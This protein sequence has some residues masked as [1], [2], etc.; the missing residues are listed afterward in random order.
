ML[1]ISHN[2]GLIRETCDR[3]CVMY[4]GQAVE[5]GTI[6]QI[7]AAPRHPYTQGL[8]GCIPTPGRDK[9]SRP[10]VPI[11]GQLPLP[12]N[13]PKGCWF[14]PRCD[15]FE[16]GRCDAGPV[17][18]L[19]ASETR[20]VRCLRWEEI[21]ASLSSRAPVPAPLEVMP[22]AVAAV[23]NDL[24]VLEVS[25]M[26]KHYPIYDSS[27]AAL[28]G[29]DRTRYVRANEAIS[30]EAKGGQ[31]VAIV[32][33]S[34]CGKSTF[35]R[36]RLGDP[37]RVLQAYP[38]QIS[39]GQQQRVVIAMALLSNPSLL[40]LDEPTT[41]LDVTVEAGIV[42]LIAELSRTLGTAMLYISHNLGLIRET[43]D[44]VCVMYA[45]Q[46]VGQDQPAAGADPRPAAAAAEPAEGL[47][48][49]AALRPFR[50]R[51]LR[52]RAG[53]DAAGQRDPGSALPALGRDRGEA[54]G[55]GADRGP[56]CRHCRC[57][58]RPAGAAGHGD[59]Q[60]LPD[61]RQL[62]RRPVRQRPHPL[63]PRQ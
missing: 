18:M 25:A 63:R 9:T 52:R 30:F 56:A 59:A 12:Q 34:G 50:G 40:L 28:F 53:A 5:E 33:E 62:D 54:A 32:G 45:G 3:V 11:R 2:L 41:A 61:L 13:R 24:P 15:H 36:V 23:A 48:V 10:L 51:A 37:D 22:A 38:H 60:A 17:P 7:F 29:S 31:T 46:A 43:C 42:D 44:R 14:G 20:G 55:P 27:I 1:Y 4:A 6:G 35:A 58:Q 21:E 39:G 19:P 16:A 47:L 26:R 8:F 57:R 49:R